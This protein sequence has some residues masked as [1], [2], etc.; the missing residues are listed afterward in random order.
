MTI[1][2][3]LPAG[4]DFLDATPG[5]DNTNGTVIC[6]IGA[7][8]SG[9]SASVTIKTRTTAAIAGSAIGN[10]ASVTGN[11]FDPDTAN[12]QA[13]TTVDVQ[14][15]V[16]LDLD[17]VASNPTP[18]AGG[19][20]TYTL[21]LVNHGPS[22]ATGVTVTDPL[23]SG[24]SFISSTA[25]QGSCGASGQ[26]VTCHLGTLGAGATA[27]MILDTRVASSDAGTTVQNTATATADQPIARPQLLESSASIKPQQAPPPTPVQPRA[28]PTWRSSRRSITPASAWVSR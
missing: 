23:P 17:K 26:T 19:T 9:D 16:D 6:D 7:L 20:V 14:P 8:A 18:S 13:S 5:C 10:L 15:L 1:Q 11:E 12:N 2:D 25:S 21:S 4:L 27:V 28:A 22:A 24:L 3:S